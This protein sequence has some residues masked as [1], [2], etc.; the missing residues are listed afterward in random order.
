[1]R[2]LVFITILCVVGGGPVL[3]SLGQVYV[4]E[5]GIGPNLVMT[6]HSLDGATADNLAVY[7]GIQNLVVTQY[8][9]SWP[10]IP[11]LPKGAVPTFC[12]DIWDWS[13]GSDT[14]SDV[15][16]LGEAPDKHKETDI[17]GPMGDLK[18]QRLAELLN[19][20]WTDS[21]TNIQAAALQAA[22]WEIVNEPYPAD[23]QGYDVTGGRFYLTSSGTDQEAAMGL[24][25]GWLDLPNHD[26]VDAGNYL[27]LTSRQAQ[28]YI[29]RIPLPGAVLL[30]TLGLAA[31]GLKLRRFA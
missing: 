5:T 7:V 1:M 20:H 4:R 19:L 21:L 26:G 17:P 6:I 11:G 14:L 15:V 13:S 18:A 12:I 30:G 29:V 28:D 9:P 16:L 24:A 8:G 31:A 27:A 2:R 3:G 10:S 23:P 25:N 22:I